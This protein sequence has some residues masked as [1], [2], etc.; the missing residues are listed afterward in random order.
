MVTEQSIDISRINKSDFNTGSE[1]SWV[2][3][4]GVCLVFYYYLV[5]VFFPV[6]GL[7]FSGCAVA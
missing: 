2:L 4:L 3:F 7:D 6:F 1:L 5:F